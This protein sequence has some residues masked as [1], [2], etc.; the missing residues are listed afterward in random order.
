[1]P[2]FS[3]IDEQTLKEQEKNVAPEMR[4]SNETFIDKILQKSIHS[5][6]VTTSFK[7]D[8]R[9]NF[10][11]N[12]TNSLGVFELEEVY[13]FAHR[14]MADLGC[15]QNLIATNQRNQIPSR[16]NETKQ[17][18]EHYQKKMLER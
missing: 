11:P 18:F 12:L 17:R 5:D 4:W 10:K 16:I 8:R 14:M 3:K 7:F 15:I 9:N 13:R 1:M 2:K 6:F